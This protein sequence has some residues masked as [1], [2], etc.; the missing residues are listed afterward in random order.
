[1]QLN[2]TIKLIILSAIMPSVIMLSVVVFYSCL[3]LHALVKHPLSW[4]MVVTISV[5]YGHQ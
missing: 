3:S 5:Q 4:S 2:V 1:M